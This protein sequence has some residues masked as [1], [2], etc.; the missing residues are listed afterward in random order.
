MKFKKCVFIVTLKYL[1]KNALYEGLLK[2]SG[3]SL[4]QID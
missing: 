4:Y 1:H 2:S 3:S